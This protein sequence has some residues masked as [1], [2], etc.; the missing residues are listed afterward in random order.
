[1]FL[2]F[3]NFI[4]LR[5]L[6]MLTKAILLQKLCIFFLFL[7]FLST[8]FWILSML[9]FKGIVTKDLNWTILPLKKK[10]NKYN[11]NQLKVQMYK[12]CL[13]NWLFERNLRREKLVHL[14]PSALHFINEF[15]A[16]KKTHGLTHT[17]GILFSIFRYYRNLWYKNLD[18]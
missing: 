14:L 9:Y 13:R 16:N 10:T 18:L 3:R 2:N 17:T 15:W 8:L 1:M 11:S 7:S 12:P 5:L 4:L 6:K